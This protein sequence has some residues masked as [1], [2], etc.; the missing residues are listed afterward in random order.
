MAS[1]GSV[2]P[3]PETENPVTSRHEFLQRVHDLLAPRGYLEIGVDDGRSL[4]LSRAPTVAV[5]PVDRLAVSV[6]CDLHFVQAT[7]DE[8]FTHP[9]PIGHLPGRQVDLAFI[10]GMHLFEYALRD[11]MNVERLSHPGTVVVLDDMLPRNTKEAARK[12]H[13]RAWTGDVYKIQ[14]VLARYRPDLVCVPVDTQPTGVL[15]VFGLDASNRTLSEA[16]DEI[17]TEWVV[18]DPQMVPEEV[19]RRTIAVAPERILEAE[20]WSWLVAR[21]RRSALRRPQASRTVARRVRVELAGRHH[22][23]AGGL[24]GRGAA[25]GG[26]LRRVVKPRTRLRRWRRRMEQRR[27]GA[28][29]RSDRNR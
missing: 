29:Q 4:A 12:R 26:A 16:Y 7:S 13:S 10:D 17:I 28:H 18:E 9:D 2:T 20:I 25:W 22:P 5:D 24:L 15:L 19:L 3:L 21:R 27:V 1:H 11:F 8:F 6:Q 23:P 14:Q